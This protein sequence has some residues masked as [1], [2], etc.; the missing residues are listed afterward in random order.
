MLFNLHTS[1]KNYVWLISQTTCIF[2][3]VK[4]TIPTTVPKLAFRLF[5]KLILQQDNI[6]TVSSGIR[7]KLC[8][9]ALCLDHSVISN[10]K[11]VVD[12]CPYSAGW[13]W[14]AC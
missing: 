3:L 1:V 9:E 6:I 5:K 14:T 2:A 8:P 13:F 10:I 4:I 11:L 12:V 7:R